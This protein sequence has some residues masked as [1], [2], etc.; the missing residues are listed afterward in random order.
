MEDTHWVEK[1]DGVLVTDWI[2]SSRPTDSKAEKQN[3]VKRPTQ[4]RG[5]SIV[6]V[7][8]RLDS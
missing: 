7:P 1:P 6:T 8:D 4:Q 5:E 3:Q 2:D